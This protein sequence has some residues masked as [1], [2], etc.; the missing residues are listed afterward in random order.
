VA[1]ATLLG[2]GAEPIEAKDP[3]HANRPTGERRGEMTRPMRFAALVAPLAIA[4]V[5]AGAAHGSQLIDRNATHVTL[6]VNAKREA[7]IT[8]TDGGKLKH[9]LVWDAVNA[10]PPTKGRT[11]VAFKLDYSG[12][13]GKYKQTSYWLNFAG[14]CLPYDGP[15]LAWKVTACKAPDGSYW[16]LQAWQRALPDYGVAPTAA[17]SAMELRLS[18]W[19][20]ELPVLSITS[21]WSY[22]KFD[23]IFGTYTY[24]GIGVYGF[25]STSSGNPLDSFGRNIYVDT[26]DSAYG[27][28]WKRDN[29]FLTHQP[30]GSFCYGFYAHGAHP[31]A[32]GSQ[33]RATAEGPGVA[34]DVMWQGAA[35]GPYDQAADATANAALTALGDKQCHAN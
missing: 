30:K 9:V 25:K 35:P 1:N 11:Q 6:V 27:A 29:S 13:Y 2:L 21:D 34:P 14:G 15:A 3:V 19:T 18:H 31:A 22:R 26:F 24:G 23:Q 8:Y 4:A 12:G 33:Y 5:A 17:Q 10:V 16:A 28:G 7:M 20:G 32:N